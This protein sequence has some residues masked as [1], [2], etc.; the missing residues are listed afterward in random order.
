MGQIR[1]QR[2]AVVT[3]SSGVV[4]SVREGQAF[5]SSD[6]VVTE[7]SWLF[8]PPVEEATAEPGQRRNAPKR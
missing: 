1:A 4:E 5:D 2:S 8:D 6:A 3:L 7:H